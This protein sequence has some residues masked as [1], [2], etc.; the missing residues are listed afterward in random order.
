M[1]T[2]STTVDLSTPVAAAH[3]QPPRR[4]RPRWPPWPAAGSR[5][6]SARRGSC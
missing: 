6:A 1:S 2:V 5:S 3:S 4:P